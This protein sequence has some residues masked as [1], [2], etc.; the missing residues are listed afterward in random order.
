MQRYKDL[1]HYCYRPKHRGLDK[2]A[3]K[4]LACASVLCATFMVLQFV[5]GILANSLVIATDAVH[6]LADLTGFLINIV[7]LWLSSK[8]PTRTMTF[9]WYR[10]EVVGALTSAL[11]IWAVTGVLVFWAIDRIFNEE[12]GINAG[13]M[14]VSAVM[15]MVLNIMMG[16]TL[17][18]GGV[19]PGH[20]HSHRQDR[21]NSSHHSHSSGQSQVLT[22]G[23]PCKSPPDTT[24][25]TR[26]AGRRNLNLRAAMMHVVSD[27]IESIGVLV[28]AIVIYCKP[29][30]HLADPLCTFLF[31]ALVLMST[32][33][34][35]KEALNVILEGKPRSIDFEEVLRVMSKESGVHH[36]HCLRI[37]ALSV[38][39]PILTAHIVIMPQADPLQLMDNISRTLH[40]KYNIFELTMQTE[41]FV[42][43]AEKL[44]CR[45]PKTP[46]SMSVTSAGGS[47]R[48]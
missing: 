40:T 2:A 44:R 8:P 5:G 24:V 6:M 45:E 48:Q 17:N 26:Q 12:T 25:D 18:A 13:I 20:G 3:F 10:A 29:E 11:F 19:S 7:A 23:S 39:R 21:E 28:A 42:G 35:A 9:G 36:V 15:G 46:T 30:Y 1:V 31:S 37:W 47:R 41:G 14:L 38:G 16:L 32:V 43:S 4:R 27:F 22:Q 34:I 33:P